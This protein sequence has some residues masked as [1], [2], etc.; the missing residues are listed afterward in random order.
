MFI[1]DNIGMQDAVTKTYKTYACE[2]R[3]GTIAP[4]GEGYRLYQ[5]AHGYNLFK[6]LYRK[7]G[8][9]PSLQVLNNPYTDWWVS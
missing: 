7:D 1:Y 8:S 4:V 6:T 3:P 5:N 9:H 2:F